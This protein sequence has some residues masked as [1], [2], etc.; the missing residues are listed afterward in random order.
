MVDAD[1]LIAGVLTS[2]GATSRLLDAWEA[3]DFELVVCQQLI[4]EVRKALLSPR[5]SERYAIT[6]ADA[7]AFA[8]KL[9][10]EGLMVE[11]PEDPPRVVPDDPNDDYL[12]ALVQDSRSG[13]LVTRDR[14]F[15]KVD[16]EDVR[17][18]NP[19]LALTLLP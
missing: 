18:V 1:C 7:E 8:R 2:Q 9:H 12:V 19:S 3:G 6:A 11:D 13:I 5:I 14:H 10:E 15:E 16:V 4:Y 17:I